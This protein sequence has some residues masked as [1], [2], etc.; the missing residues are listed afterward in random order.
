MVFE[1]SWTVL[2]FIAYECHAVWILTTANHKKSIPAKC[3]WIFNLQK[4]LTFKYVKG[5]F[6]IVSLSS[7]YHIRIQQPISQAISQQG[8][9]L[10]NFHKV[11]NFGKHWQNWQT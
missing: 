1:L 4:I 11:Y 9:N 7:Q 2:N 8:I 5:N 6:E 10:N 3:N